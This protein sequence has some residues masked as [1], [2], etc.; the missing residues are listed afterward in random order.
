[1]LTDLISAAVCNGTK[2]TCENAFEKIEEFDGY[3]RV[4]TQNETYQAKNIVFCSPD[5]I[6]RLFGAKIKYGYAPMGVYEGVSNNE[7]SFVQLDFN[8]RNCIN[9]LKKR[10]GYAL[11]GGIT[12]DKINDVKDYFDYVN[13]EHMKKNPNLRL[14]YSYIGVKKELIDMKSARNYQY[15]IKQNTKRQW[16]VVLGK[17]SLFPSLSVEF[18]RRVYSKNSVLAPIFEKSAS[19]HALVAPTYWSE[20]THKKDI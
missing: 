13:S 19:K 17:F 5:L 8:T 9:L 14:V 16:S 20:I 3:V 15:H 10:D 18:Y 1:M 4:Y 2:I 6:A 7:S 12:M 11:A